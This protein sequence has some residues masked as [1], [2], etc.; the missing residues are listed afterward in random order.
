MD[1]FDSFLD[2]LN[3]GPRVRAAQHQ[4]DVG[5]DFTFAVQ[6]GSA[7][8]DRMADPH[9]RHVAEKHRNPAGFFNH[10]V[11]NVSRRA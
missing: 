5:D 10:N 11:F 6:H 7:V 4:D 3:H 2:R 8:P 9:L 1:L